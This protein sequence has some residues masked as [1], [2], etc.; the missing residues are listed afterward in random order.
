VWL[1]LTAE[2]GQMTHLYFE[3]SAV[4]ITLVM[5]GKWLELRAKRQTTSAIR[6]LHALRPPLAHVMLKSGETVDVPVSEVLC[7]DVVVVMPGER[8]PVDGELSQ[9]HTQVDESMLTGEPLPV[10][11]ALGAL[12]TGGSI[13][14]DGQVR[15]RV[16]A[17]GADT[18]LARIIG[19]VEDAQAGK[20]PIQRLVDHVSAVFVPAVLVL[21]VVTLGGWLWTGHSV[22]LSLI[23]AVA[24][25]VIACP[26]SLGLA[27]PAAIMAGTGV[28]AGFTLT[29]APFISFGFDRNS[30]PG[31]ALFLR[32]SAYLATSAV[33]PELPTGN[34]PRSGS[35]WVACSG[36]SETVYEWG[37]GGGAANS[38]SGTL[39][40]TW[41]VVG[42]S[43]DCFQGPSV[44]NGAWNHLAFTYGAGNNMI[45]YRNGVAVRTCASS[46]CAAAA[47][48]R[49]VAVC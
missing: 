46:A 22:E 44:C 6:A 39:A 1:W 15:M 4:V 16:T 3:A 49:A 17:V 42:E 5:L 25:L 12:L 24:V 23:H 26:C 37:G 28:A 47:A 38:R 21:A 36:A 8:M 41:G 20:A 11:K 13:N 7:G 27:T 43:N 33:V 18:V 35:V 30:C 29:N 32:N 45:I 9:G 10:A 19:L 14:G 40:N 31:G 34:A 2:P 48:Q